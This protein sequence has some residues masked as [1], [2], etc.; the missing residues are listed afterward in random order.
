ML[1]NQGK[2]ILQGRVSDVKN[3]NKEHKYSIEFDGRLPETL[4]GDFHIVDDSDKELIIKI[5]EGSNAN[6]L[7]RELI[8]Q[9]FVIRSFREILPSLNEIFIKKVE[10]ENHE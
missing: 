10:N 4:R 7:L 6:E 9:G 8:N 3:A 1:I 5:D 2:N